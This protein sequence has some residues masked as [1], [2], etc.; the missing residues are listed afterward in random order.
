ML[1]TIFVRQNNNTNSAVYG[2]AS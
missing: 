2:A 1:Q